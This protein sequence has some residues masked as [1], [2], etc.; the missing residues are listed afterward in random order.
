MTALKHKLIQAGFAAFGMSRLHRLLAPLTRGIGAI[1]TFHHVRP[2]KAESFA[3]NRVLEITPD[4]LDRLLARATASGYRLIPLDR[5]PDALNEPEAQ[6]FLAL[7]F[8]D[9]YRDN[10]EHALPVLESHAAPFTL[11]ATTG[12]ADRSAR[13]WWHE[14]EEAIRR[15]TQIEFRVGSARQRFTTVTSAQKSR[16]FAAI[17]RV[18]VSRS[19]DERLA[20]VGSLVAAARLDSRALVDQLCMTWDELAQLAAHPLAAIGCHTTTHARLA[21]LPRLAVI[22]E[23]AEARSRLEARLGVE[24]RHLSYPYGNQSAAGSREFEIASELGFSTATTTRPGVLFPDDAK[25][26]TALP[27]ISING[28][29]QTIE[30]TDILL[31]GAPFAFWNHGRRITV[32]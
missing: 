28:L 5:V 1:L 15:L 8:D 2:W 20:A 31:S 23:I 24:I 12:F 22:R 25:H 29:W 18:L 10:V 14:L 16:C 32:A 17:M 13:L 9:G 11:F 6:P 21:S 4:F 27:R 30:A 3:P 7:T 26:R 19:D